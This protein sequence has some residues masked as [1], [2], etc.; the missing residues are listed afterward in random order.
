MH[1]FRSTRFG[2][3]CATLFCVGL[4]LIL[5]LGLLPALLAGLL[6]FSLVNVMVPIL[7]VQG[8]GR[9]WSRLLAVAVIASAVVSLI[10]VIGFGL[11]YLVRHSG[12]SVPALFTRMAQILEQSRENLPSW[13]IQYIPD[14]AEAFRLT[15][16]QWLR[17]NAGA[18][19]VA[20]AE[21]GGVLGHILIGIIVGGLMSLETAISGPELGPLGRELARSA[22]RLEQAFRRVIFSQILISA[23]NTA[24]TALYLV[25]FLPWFGY[26][27]PFTKT[28]ILVTFLVGLLP[29]IG[30][31]ISNTIIFI[32]SLSQSGAVAIASL[33]YLVIIHKLEYFLNVRI[34]GTQIRAKAWELLIAF[35]LMEAAFGLAGLIAAPIYYAYLKEELTERKL[36]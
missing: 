3:I 14:D 31:L 1:D 12:E 9:D 23:I 10:I 5:S 4:L 6:V 30:N 8:L 2:L 28:L 15:F 17:E 32:V 25:I 7:G 13:L 34:I 27:L 21:F 24:F 29:I 22:E 16:V 36:I 19:R 20:G 35:L 18:F 33:A 11:G 26:N